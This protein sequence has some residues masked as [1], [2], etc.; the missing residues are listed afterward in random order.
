MNANVVAGLNPE[1]GYPTHSQTPSSKWKNYV[2]ALAIIVGIGTSLAVLGVGAASYCQM[3]FLS[4][5]AQ[6][7]ALIAMV[8]G[9]AFFLFLVATVC[10]VKMYSSYKNAS[11][12]LGTATHK[13]ASTSTT[14]FSAKQGRVYGPDEW[15]ELGKKRKCKIEILNEIPPAPSGEVPEGK[16]WIY[17]PKKV[18]IKDEIE[19]RDL[20]LNV[21]KEIF[22]ELLDCSERIKSSF[23]DH[24]AVSGW[25]ELEECLRP[26]SDD[27]DDSQLKE[28][29]EATGCRLPNFMEPVV[30][31]LMVYTFSNEKYL[32]GS[33]PLLAYTLCKEVCQ[34]E[35]HNEPSNRPIL[36]GGFGSD[37][38]LGVMT[39][40]SLPCPG[41]GVIGVRELG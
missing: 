5:I 24:P 14:S 32:L 27:K 40:E 13:A 7:D 17:I 38:G 3:G 30:A 36:V 29:V 39:A 20:T 12:S 35:E 25:F 19:E 1:S 26:D 6:I 28:M 9:G 41:S 2:F 8:A 11:E 22:G 18:R 31:N 4:H 15:V 34:D 37:V 10:A 23:M 21:L 33:G 16:I